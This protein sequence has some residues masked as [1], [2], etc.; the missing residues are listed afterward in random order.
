MDIFSKEIETSLFEKL[1]DNAKTMFK[2]SIDDEL[3]E[4]IVTTLANAKNPV[5][6]IGG[7]VML[8]DA[9]EELREF[10]D[11]MGIP[12]S[13]SLMGKGILPDDHPLILGMTGFWGA[14]FIND[15][16]R[17]ADYILGLGTSFK[18]ADCSSWYDE[19]TFSFPPTKLIHIDIDPSELGRN[20]PVEIGAVADLKNALRVL[21]RVAKKLY[22]NARQNQAL[23]EEIAA[24]KIEFKATS[25]R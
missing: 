24:Y 25:W 11:H 6:H 5:I 14:K 15:K 10:V 17:N 23:K 21:N 18:E 9:A 7:G 8:A 4:K 3:A 16:C 19:Y 1:A 22:P 2:P 12:V 13:H 20:Y